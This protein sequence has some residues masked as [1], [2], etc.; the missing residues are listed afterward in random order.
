MFWGARSGLL[1]GPKQ[2]HWILGTGNSQSHSQIR[3][4]PRPPPSLFQAPP[5]SFCDQ[6]EG[7]DPHMNTPAPPLRPKS[8]LKGARKVRFWGERLFGGFSTLESITSGHDLLAKRIKTISSL[9]AKKNAHTHL[10]QISYLP[11]SLP[12]TKPH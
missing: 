3:P 4:R 11:I 2:G 5:S 1:F 7:R 10:I 12:G 9:F 6:A 8:D